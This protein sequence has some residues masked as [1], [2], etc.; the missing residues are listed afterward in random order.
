M[1]EVHAYEQS[2]GL[3]GVESQVL[4]ALVARLGPLQLGRPGHLLGLILQLLGSDEE[5]CGAAGLHALRQ[6]LLE[7]V[8]ELLLLL[9]ALH[10]LPELGHF[11]PLHPA[12]L[13]QQL[14]FT[15]FQ[16]GVQQVEAL[17]QPPPLLL[18][19]L[20]DQFARVV[21]LCHDGLD[22]AVSCGE[23]LHSRAQLVLLALV[24]SV[25]RR[26][27]AVFVLPKHFAHGA[28]GCL[29][30][31]AVDVDAFVLVFLA[32]WL[33]GVFVLQGDV[34]TV[35]P[36][37][38]LL[39]LADVDDVLHQQVPLQP[40][41][42][43]PVQNHLEAAGGAAEGSPGVV[44][45]IPG[46]VEVVGAAAAKIVLAGQDHHRLGEHV[47]ADGAAELLLQALHGADRTHELTRLDVHLLRFLLVL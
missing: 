38:L 35:T 29:A 36:L 42:A 46:L 12:D 14:T 13:L 11:V 27:L 30:A 39:L 7:L 19:I 22:A 1:S 23:Q 16:D 6:F 26:H 31:H 33:L 45:R 47:E 25:Q 43:V 3:L 18:S 44:V 37:A 2:L 9:V 17:A 8:A 15:L 5:L 40:V 20:L 41:H 28:G 4:H 34:L 32:L 21:H 10:Q 24:N